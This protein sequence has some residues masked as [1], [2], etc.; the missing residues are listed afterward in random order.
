MKIAVECTSP[1]LQKSLEVFLVKYLSSRKLCD[2][3]IR[4]EACLN[5]IR[6]FY[7]SSKSGSDL[8]KPFSKGQLILSLEKKYESLTKSKQKISSKSSK[9]EPLNFEILEKRIDYLTQEYKQSILKAIQAF[10]EK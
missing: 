5:D 4:D 9:N 1:L 7:I 2:I 6:C 10:Y 8:L 3:V